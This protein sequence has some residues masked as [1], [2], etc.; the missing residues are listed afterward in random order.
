MRFVYFHRSHKRHILKF[1]TCN[2]SASFEARLNFNDQPFVS[3][4]VIL[5]TGVHWQCHSVVTTREEYV[6][7]LLIDFTSHRTYTRVFDTRFGACWHRNGL[8]LWITS[9]YDN[10]TF[11][12]KSMHLEKFVK[13]N[14]RRD[15]VLLP[16]LQSWRIHDLSLHGVY[17]THSDGAL[18]MMRGSGVWLGE[19]YR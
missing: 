5:F 10:T 13:S 3:I 4:Y 9:R 11:A 12:W 17:F 16:C 2:L 18:K 7:V 14:L 19:D 8:V 15:P 6:F 1:Q